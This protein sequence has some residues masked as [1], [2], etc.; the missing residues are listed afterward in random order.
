MDDVS[1]EHNCVVVVE[2][3]EVAYRCVLVKLALRS[4][5]GCLWWCQKLNVVVVVVAVLGDMVGGVSV[6]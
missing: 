1:L 5:I 6:G 4:V 2:V 3:L